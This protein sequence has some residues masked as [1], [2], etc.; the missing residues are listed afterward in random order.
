MIF[1]CCISVFEKRLVNPSQ[2]AGPSISNTNSVYPH[3]KCSVDFGAMACMFTIL[4][5]D[6]LC[7]CSTLLQDVLYMD[8]VSCLCM[9]RN[10]YHTRRIFFSICVIHAF[11]LHS[12]RLLGVEF[13]TCFYV[14]C[15]GHTVVQHKQRH[16][17]SYAKHLHILLKGCQTFC[18]CV[19]KRGHTYIGFWRLGLQRWHTLDLATVS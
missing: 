14:F 10:Q 3:F 5:S 6:D 7:V 4:K 12:V 1:T 17:F 16:A 9:H 19:N 8:S 2:G 11:D 18:C 13:N 15:V